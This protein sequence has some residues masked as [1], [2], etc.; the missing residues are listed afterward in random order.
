MILLWVNQLHFCDRNSY[1][2]FLEYEVVFVNS[3]QL[4]QD[5]Y[6]KC[7]HIW[8]NNRCHLHFGRNH[9]LGLCSTPC[10][11]L[12]MLWY[13]KI[14]IIFV[15][16]IKKKISKSICYFVLRSSRYDQHLWLK[17]KRIKTIWNNFYLGK[18]SNNFTKL[19]T[20]Q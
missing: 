2:D 6:I 10:D 11:S 16:K 15:I 1:Q 3:K 13:N 20:F 5:T 17:Y 19:F 12:K 9:M 14:I 7:L 4:W 18:S 8:P